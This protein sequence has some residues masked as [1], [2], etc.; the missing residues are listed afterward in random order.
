MTDHVT[1]ALLDQLADA[2]VAIRDYQAMPGRHDLVTYAMQCVSRAE[3][4]AKLA[5]T[6]EHATLHAV[7]G[8]LNKDDV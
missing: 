4:L 3:S 6:P 1:P 2:R 5:M 7:M 8:I